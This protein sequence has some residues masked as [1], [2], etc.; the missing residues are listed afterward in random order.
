VPPGPAGAAAWRTW[1]VAVKWNVLPLPGSLSTQTP[2]PISS[3]RRVEMV[4]PRPVPPYLSRGTAVGLLER[5]EDGV[6]PFRRN[7]DAS[8]AHGEM[9]GNHCHENA[10]ISIVA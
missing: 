9:Q 3:T 4:S 1:K 5:P 2:P 7:A 6:Q 8:V 10:D